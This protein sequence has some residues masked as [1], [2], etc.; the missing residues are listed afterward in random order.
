M[1]AGQSSERRPLTSLQRSTVLA[2]I[3]APAAGAYV[4][5]R[6]SELAEEIQVPLLKRAWE[7]VMQRHP[8]LRTSVVIDAD[9]GLW[10]HVNEKPE[11]SWRE[12]DWTGVEP[13]QREE[14]L[15]AFLL[16]DWE[17]GFNFDEGVPARFTILRNS[18]RSYTLIWTSHHVL[19][20]GGSIPIV[21]RDWFALYYGLLRGEAVQLAEPQPFSVYLD[22]LEGQDL[23]KAERFWRE[24]LAGLSQTTDYVVDRLLQFSFQKGC[25]RRRILFIL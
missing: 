5:Q 2:S 4:I 8:A 6:I 14:K 12:L 15:A 24:Y 11:I 7:L 22:W 9:G 18:E 16:Q 21:W 20:D 3:R 10:Q 13:A 23:A 19:L 1:I 25:V 17:R